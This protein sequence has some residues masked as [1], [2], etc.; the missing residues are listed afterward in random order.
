M[1]FATGEL[2]SQS[3][4]KSDKTRRTSQGG[5]SQARFQRNI[6]NMHQ[7]HVKEVVDALDRIVTQEGIEQILT[8]GD[9]VVLPL[10]RDQMPKH[11]ADKVVDHLKI[12]S[13]APVDEILAA[14]VEA[15]G[16]LNEQSDKDKVEAAIGGHRGGNL[17][18]VGP[19]ATLE[20][21]I[22]GQVDELL[23]SANIASLK[24]VSP[25]AAAMAERQHADRIRRSKPPPAAKPRRP[26]RRWCGLPTNSSPAPTTRARR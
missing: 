3:E 22:K 24:N 9:E 6:A 19:E 16:R 17:G 1:V 23:L 8:V 14:T 18:V 11:L 15:M 5:W 25:R 2:E 13:K 12:D 20:A 7:Q 21:L 10:L 26:I 4:V